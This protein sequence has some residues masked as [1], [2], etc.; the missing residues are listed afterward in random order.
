MSCT[1]LLTFRQGWLSESSLM[2]WPADSQP[3]KSS[4]Q[5]LYF[6]MTPS[7]S[8]LWF[9]SLRPTFPQAGK[10]H[11]RVLYFWTFKTNLLICTV[12]MDVSSLGFVLWTDLLTSNQQFFFCRF[13]MLGWTADLLPRMFPLWV[14][15][16]RLTCWPPA[17][18]VSSMGF[19]C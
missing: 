11:H 15:Y 8:P 5:G 18:D 6:E 16:A 17:K 9:L 13:C 19:V 7:T 1:V 10:S 2:E 14:L 4:P 3:G 12:P